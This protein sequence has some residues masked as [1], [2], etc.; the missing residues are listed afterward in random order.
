MLPRSRPR[1]TLPRLTRSL[2]TLC[3]ASLVATACHPAIHTIADPSMAS[4]VVRNTSVFDINVYALPTDQGQ[5][6]WLATV[7]GSQTRSLGVNKRQ[8]QRDG[9]LVVRAQALGSSRVW[10]SGKIELDEATI[11]VLDLSS[12]WIG[13]VSTSQLYAVTR[14]ITLVAPDR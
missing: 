7:P 11:A 1:R 13:D 10:T 9:G 6:V 12:D 14:P 3:V 2:A 5:P 8:L 4:L